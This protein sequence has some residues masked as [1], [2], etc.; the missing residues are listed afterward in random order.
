MTKK[1]IIVII[2]VGIFIFALVA[3]DRVNQMYRN[4]VNLDE[5]A[6]MASAVKSPFE[7]NFNV[8]GTLEEAGT[9]YESTNPYWW[10]DSGGMMIIHSGIGSTAQ[11]SLPAENKWRMLY[12][13]SNPVDT[14][15][16]VR[17]Q[18]IFRLLTRSYWHNFRQ[19]MYFRV[20]AH[21][22]SQSPNR[23]ESNGLLLI[24][25]YQN[26]NN[27][28]YA[29]VRVDGHVIIKKKKGGEYHTLYEEPIFPGIYSREENHNFIPKDI[30]IGVR[31]DI[32]SLSQ[33]HVKIRLFTDIGETGTWKLVADADDYGTV[34]GSVINERGLAGVRTDFMDVSFKKYRI[35]EL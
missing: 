20:N 26:Q 8:D 4:N 2:I 23:D 9:I 24:S 14:D 17:P 16:G 3:G 35:E 6:S 32:I 10:L 5:V 30:W 31:T 29:G 7:Y 34:Y 27:L 15:N 25:R 21:N 11:G 18:N 13:S 33:S 28:Y 12:A 22:I 19:E 1:I